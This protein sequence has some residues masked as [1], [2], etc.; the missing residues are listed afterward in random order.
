ML[1]QITVWVFY[2][3][4]IFC[5]GFTAILSCKKNDH[6]LVGLEPMPICRQK[7]LQMCYSR[8]IFEIIQRLFYDCIWFFCERF[9][10]NRMLA[11]VH[12][13]TIGMFLWFSFRFTEWMPAIFRYGSQIV[14][15]RRWV[16]AIGLASMCACTTYL[17]MFCCPKRQKATSLLPW[18]ENWV[19]YTGVYWRRK[20]VNSGSD[21]GTRVSHSNMS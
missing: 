4:R 3:V 8:N 9:G 12:G 20:R 5:A 19:Q 18:N 6:A 2:V 7:M 15:T 1:R 10:G 14:T 21:S 16:T 13:G 11:L 17:V